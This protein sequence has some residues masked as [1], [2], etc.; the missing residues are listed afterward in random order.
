ME[1]SRIPPTNCRMTPRPPLE[2]IVPDCAVRSPVTRRIRVVLPAPFGPTSAATRPSPTR[3]E[4][5]SSS[6]RPS[7][8]V[9]VRCAASTWPISAPR[10]VFAG[11]P[12]LAS[13]R[14]GGRPHDTKRCPP[15]QFNGFSGV[16]MPAPRQSDAGQARLARPGAGNTGGVC[17]TM[18][19]WT[20]RASAR[21]P[22]F[23][24]R[25]P[26]ATRPRRC[27]TTPWPRGGSP[28]MST[29]S[30]WTRSTPPRP[31]PTS[32]R[33]WTTCLVTA[34]RW[35]RSRGPARWPRRGR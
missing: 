16:W 10:F 30:G 6:T 7:G 2:L 1:S 32:C 26:T 34:P 8:S 35:R 28:S 23:A 14:S 17:P 19:A 3:N 12:Y 27:S 29:P 15:A 4:T 24:P 11:R 25:T 31:T 20:R 22:G 5:S 18:A 13:G 9:W 33:C 21:T